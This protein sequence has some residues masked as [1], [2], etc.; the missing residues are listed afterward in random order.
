MRRALA[1]IVPVRNQVS[2]PLFQHTCNASYVCNV[3]RR[4]TCKFTYLMTYICELVSR[5]A[6]RAVLGLM[7]DGGN[8]LASG[9][10]WLSVTSFMHPSWAILLLFAY[11]L[12]ELNEVIVRY[13]GRW[14]RYV[15]DA[16]FL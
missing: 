12:F 15:Y 3:S 5:A 2:D 13:V 9:L 16:G 11:S 14:R 1:L 8:C 7:L 4:G 10:L 6:I